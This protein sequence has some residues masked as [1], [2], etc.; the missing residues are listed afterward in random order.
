MSRTSHSSEELDFLGRPPSENSSEEVH[1]DET[2]ESTQSNSNH[3]SEELDYL[4]QPPSRSLSPS[5]ENSPVMFCFFFLIHCVKVKSFH[6]FFSSL[7][8]VQPAPA[9]RPRKRKQSQHEIMAK[10]IEQ[11]RRTT[12][13]LIPRAPFQRL[14]RELLQKAIYDRNQTSFRLQSNALEALRESTEMF[15]CTMFEDATLLV[16]H[17]GRKTLIGRDLRLLQYLKKSIYAYHQPVL[18]E[19]PNKKKVRFAPWMRKM[20][21]LS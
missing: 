16:L 6:W 5:T 14:V 7:I 20:W 1:E 15:I 18:C 4:G 11:F 8:F 3:A 10:R 13:L 21:N 9:P 19:K 2:S 17:R 12:N